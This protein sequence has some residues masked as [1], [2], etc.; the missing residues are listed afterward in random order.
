MSRRSVGECRVVLNGTDDL[1]RSLLLY[2]TARGAGKTVIDAYA[3][4]LPSVYVTRPDEQMP[5][6]RLGYPT[7]GTAW[8]A[9]TTEQRALLSCARSST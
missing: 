2:R 1:R 8:N 3:S 4:S 6:E 9:L 7:I 5:E